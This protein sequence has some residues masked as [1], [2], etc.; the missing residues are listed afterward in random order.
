MA[1]RK[2]NR[3]C[4]CYICSPED[5]VL[6]KRY[7]NKKQDLKEIR[8]YLKEIDYGEEPEPGELY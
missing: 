3:K 1:K 7:Q 8:S 6:Q 2:Y 5:R 4:H